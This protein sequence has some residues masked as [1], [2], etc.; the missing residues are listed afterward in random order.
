M[1]L[2]EIHEKKKA[3]SKNNKVS[4]KRPSLAVASTSKPSKKNKKITK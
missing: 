4:P 1:V 3:K 2:L